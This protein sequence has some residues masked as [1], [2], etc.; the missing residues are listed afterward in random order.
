MSIDAVLDQY[1]SGKLSRRQ[2]LQA[3]AVVGGLQRP[4]AGALFP[5]RNLNH[6]T[7]S[8]ADV[9][10][11]REFYERLLGGIV[12][13]EPRPASVDLRIGDSFVGMAKSPNAGRVDH[14]CVGI[15]KYAPAEGLEKAKAAGLNASL[16]GNGQQLFITDPDGIR[17][18]IASVDYLR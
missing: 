10:R 15:D 4:A 7:L 9:A 18:Q 14:F 11:S 2:L 5:A 3:L 6:V 8:V 13:G 12:V 17:V 16:V 1:D